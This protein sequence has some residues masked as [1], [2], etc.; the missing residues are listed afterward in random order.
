M[1]RFFYALYLTAYCFLWIWGRFFSVIPPW[2]I[3]SSLR[4]E[5]CWHCEERYPSP[6]LSYCQRCINELSQQ[7]EAE[8]EA[9]DG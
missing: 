6:G 3:I 5:R 7:Y 9:H 2:R 8:M 1:K 4:F